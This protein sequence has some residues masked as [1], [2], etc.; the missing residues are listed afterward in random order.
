MRCSTADADRGEFYTFQV[1]LFAA[2]QPLDAH[3]RHVLGLQDDRRRDHPGLPPRGA[4]T[5]AAATGWAARSR[6]PSRCHRAR[7]RRSGWGSRCRNRRRRRLHGRGD[8]RARPASRRRASPVTITVSNR[9]IPASGDDEPARHSRLR[10]LDSTLALDDEVVGPVHAGRR[11]G[12]TP[13]ASSAA[14]SCVGRDGFPERIQSRFTQEMTSIGEKP[15]D[16]PRRPRSA[17]SPRGD[18]RLPGLDHLGSAVR[19]AAPPAPCR[20]SPDATAG[21]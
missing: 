10:W 12:T 17:S 2:R 1:G 15:R 18:A 7:C 6:R 5:S 16:S 21:R 9:I 3:R 14:P 20:G 4:S 13:S 8:D 11:C 19:E